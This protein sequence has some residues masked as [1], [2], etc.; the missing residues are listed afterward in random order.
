MSAEDLQELY[1][2][3]GEIL[4]RALDLIDRDQIKVYLPAKRDRQLLE[5]YG[6]RG[7]IYRFFPNISYCPC[8]FFK[9]FVLAQQ[10]EFTCKHVLAARLATILD[11]SKEEIITDDAF[12][13][14][15]TEVARDCT[16]YKAT[17]CDEP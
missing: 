17:G 2:I 3:F 6:Q 14:L 9:H 11:R 8:N 4:E 12:T 10:T 7:A 15:I 1:G 16:N 13:F 5:I